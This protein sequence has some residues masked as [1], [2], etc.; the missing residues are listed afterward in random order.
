MRD[1]AVIA[2]AG[3]KALLDGE[4]YKHRISLMRHTHQ[5]GDVFI[6]KVGAEIGVAWMLWRRHPD[7]QELWCVIPYDIMS[8]M[9]M[10]GYNDIPVPEQVNCWSGI[11]RCGCSSWANESMF[12]IADR[13]G[14]VPLDYIRAVDSLMNSMVTGHGPDAV[15]ET[16]EVI[17]FDP[18]YEELVYLTRGAADTL[19][20]LLF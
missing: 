19:Y 18:D 7:E 2:A 13:V 15:D 12:L 10:C 1:L 17:E 3:R 5:P 11:L 8:S 16:M 9:L 14:V 20:N 4:Q 6:H